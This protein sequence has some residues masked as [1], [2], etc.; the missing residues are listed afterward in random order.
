MILKDALPSLNVPSNSVKT[1]SDVTFSSKYS[2]KPA[3]TSQL[4]YS[5]ANLS[6]PEDFHW[7]E[8]RSSSYTVKVPVALD[9][10]FSYGGSFLS[11]SNNFTF[12]PVWQAHPYIS[13]DTTESKIGYTKSEIDSL[14]KTDYAATKKDLTTTNSISFK[15]FY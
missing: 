8:I 7:E 10:S 4:A 9:N 6:S 14:N 1:F 13:T 12:S 3:F 11:L 15:P 5:T 2:I